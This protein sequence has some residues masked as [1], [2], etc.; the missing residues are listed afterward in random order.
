[1]IEN[2]LIEVSEESIELSFEEGFVFE[3]FEELLESDL[4]P[5]VG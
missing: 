5:V 2:V 3:G 1:M 4:L